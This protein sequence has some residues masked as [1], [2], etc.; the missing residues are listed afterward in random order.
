MI[1]NKSDRILFLIIFLIF[2][3]SL[4]FIFTK[5]DNGNIAKVLK[6]GKVILEI[7]LTLPEK[8]YKVE[9]AN[10][11]VRIL[12]GNGKIKVIEEDSPYH[13]C[14]KQGYISSSYETIVCLPNRI[15]IEISN[16]VNDELI[17]TVVR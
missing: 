14:S 3:V 16:E 9:G 10:G 2:I 4:Y 5:K 8:E 7:D 6:D 12:A 13:I 11:T 15:S 1:L 17:D